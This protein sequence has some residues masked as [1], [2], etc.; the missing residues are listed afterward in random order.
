MNFVKLS[1]YAT[2]LVSNS[3]DEMSRLL[4]GIAEDLDEECREDMLHED[5]EFSRFMVFLHQVK[6]N[7]KRNHTR[8]GN[9]SRQSEKMFS[10]KSSTEIRDKPRFKKGLFHQG[11]QVHP[12]VVMIEILSPEFRETMK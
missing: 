12:R 6:E 1:S 11:S 7:R 3:R 10:R 2:F 4:T 9:M 5:M 8:V